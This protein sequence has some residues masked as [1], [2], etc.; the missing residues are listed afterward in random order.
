[1]TQGTVSKYRTRS[2]LDPRTYARSSC[3][4]FPK[5]IL[6]AIDGSKNATRA[7][8]SGVD[9][10]RKRNA[11][12]LIVNVVQIDKYGYPHGRYTEEDARQLVDRAVS[13]SK[14]NGLPAKGIVKRAIL[15]VVETIVDCATREKVDLIVIGTR[16]LGGFKRLLLGS[17]SNG[18]V[19]HAHCN[20]LVVR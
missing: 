17:I 4:V 16:G 6:V 1:M 14:D 9:L 7:L 13:F 18:V 19:T 8:E 15:S 11:E 5:R 10:A 12:L 20:V 3:S 2:L